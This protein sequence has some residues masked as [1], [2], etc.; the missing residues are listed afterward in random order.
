MTNLEKEGEHI[1]QIT[2]IGD[3]L[4][5]L[6]KQ[7]PGLGDIPYGDARPTNLREMVETLR[8]ATIALINVHNQI[9]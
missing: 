2:V 3:C 8:K 1:F 7:N 4:D 9:N 5:N 6:L